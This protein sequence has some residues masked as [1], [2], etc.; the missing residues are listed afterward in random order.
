EA[1]LKKKFSL[2]RIS[3]P[4]PEPDSA[5]DPLQSLQFCRLPPPT[6]GRRGTLLQRPPRFPDL[7]AGPGPPRKGG[8]AVRPAVDQEPQR[9]KKKNAFRLGDARQCRTG[10]RQRTIY[11]LYSFAAFPSYRKPAKQRVSKDATIVR[12]CGQYQASP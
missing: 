3:P 1:G 4:G 11:S 2:S 9:A 5:A 6:Q 8:L 10:I 12:T 7:V